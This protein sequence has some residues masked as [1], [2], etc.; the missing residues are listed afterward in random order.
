MLNKA[1]INGMKINYSVVQRQI[2]YPRL[3]LKTGSLILIVP[4]GFKNPEKLIKEH[5]NWICD[6][7]SIIEES[8]ERSE[9]KTLNLE[10]TDE[11]LKDFIFYLILKFSKELNV[12]PKRVILRIMKSK[13]GSCSPKKNIN[14]NKLLKYLPD[15]LVEYVVL[16]EMTHLKEKTHGKEFWKIISKASSDYKEK[17]RD[18]MDYWFLISHYLEG[19]NTI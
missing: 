5:E 14:F 12:K 9:E 4:T 7:I 17:E 11:E 8:Q 2:K 15:D 19:K 10:R 6:K 3:E 18:L 1:T 16:H 13:W